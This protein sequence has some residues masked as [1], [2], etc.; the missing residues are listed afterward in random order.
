MFYVCFFFNKF[1]IFWVEWEKKRVLVPSPSLFCSHFY[2]HVCVREGQPLCR[3]LT[4]AL[5]PRGQ[6]RSP[7]TSLLHRV[8]RGLQVRTPLLI[9]WMCWAWSSACVAS[10]CGSSGV[11]GWP[12]TVPVLALPTHVWMMTPN[13]C[14]VASCCPSQ[15]L[16]CLISRTPSPWHHHGPIYEGSPYHIGL[17]GSLSLGYFMLLFH[18]RIHVFYSVFY[19]LT[20]LWCHHT[21][22][23]TFHT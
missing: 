10:W 11:L 6:T 7:D 12:S 22:F 1:A 8:P 18:D 16:W 4:T 13:R 2:L 15:R 17:Q 5:T 19:C 3:Q 9:T 21:L 14:W 20:F 23:C